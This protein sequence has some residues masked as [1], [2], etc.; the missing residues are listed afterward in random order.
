MD[1]HVLPP[2]ALKYLGLTGSRIY[3][4]I[5]FFTTKKAM[6]NGRTLRSQTGDGL[7]SPA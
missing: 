2:K 6:H 4:A 7:P 3:K 5:D 1:F